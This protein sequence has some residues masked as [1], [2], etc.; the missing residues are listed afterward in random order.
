MTEEELEWFELN[1]NKG[2]SGRKAIS[3]RREWK[4]WHNMWDDEGSGNYYSDRHCWKSSRKEHYQI[5][6]PRKNKKRKPEEKRKH[7]SKKKRQQGLRIE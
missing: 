4:L 3:N 5:K 1:W 7:S 2:M 6:H